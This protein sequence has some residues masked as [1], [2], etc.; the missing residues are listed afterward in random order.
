MASLLVYVRQ[1]LILLT[2]AEQYT[3]HNHFE[4]RISDANNLLEFI[5]EQQ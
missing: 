1:H 2:C 3:M 4:R 5:W